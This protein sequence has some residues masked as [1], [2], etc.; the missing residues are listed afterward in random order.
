[1]ASDPEKLKVLIVA[2][3]LPLVGG[4]SVQAQRLLGAFADDPAIKV[5][6]QP[7]NPV[8]LAPLQKIKFVR[9]LV[10]SA[11]YIFDLLRRV[12]KYDVIHIFSASYFSFLLAPTPAL[13]IAKLFNKKTILNY[14][15]GEAEDHLT[16]WKRTAIPLIR[17]FD[18]II[19]P[20]DYLVDVFGRF[21]LKAETIFNFVDTSN[22]RFR[23]RQ[24]LNPVFLSNRNFE[25]LYNVGCILQAFALIQQKFPVAK[26]LVAGEGREGADLRQLSKTLGLRNVEFLGSVQQ[27]EMPGLYDQA[28]IYL[29]SS[30][31]DNMPSSIIEAF[32]AG[33]PVVS[34]N[35]GGIPYI[36]KD[37]ETGLLVSLNDHEALAAAAIRL[38][39]SPELAQKIITQAR[40]DCVKYSLEAV[41][42]QWVNVYRS[43]SE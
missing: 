13:L 27:S 5:D 40:Q 41:Y 20:S 32:A 29:N 31:I 22:Y 33:T 2:P 18:K 35:A 8:F 15:S 10:T 3:T 21:G 42:P 43:L 1:M 7:I 6:I 11:K 24:P 39:D 25:S 14:H 26:L 19:V 12:P 17:R 23:E 34:T 16:R 38:L 36:V 37:G 9:T 28:D 30:N 4:Q